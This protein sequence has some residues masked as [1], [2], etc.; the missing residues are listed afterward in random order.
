VDRGERTYDPFGAQ[1]D[2]LGL[3]V[4]PSFARPQICED[5]DSGIWELGPTLANLLLDAPAGAVPSRRIIVASRHPVDSTQYSVETRVPPAPLLRS[6]PYATVPTRATRVYGFNL[7]AKY[8][9]NK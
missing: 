6:A 7:R 1:E 9:I 8:N 4:G 3:I 5:R 2:G